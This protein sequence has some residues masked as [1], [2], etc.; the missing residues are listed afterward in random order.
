MPSPN[1]TFAESRPQ[2]FTQDFQCPISSVS[3]EAIE[4]WLTGRELEGRTRFNYVRLIKTL[5]NFAQ[6]RRYFPR[7]VD[8]LEGIEREFTDLSEIEV[9]SPAEM[10]H[11]LQHAR[12]ELIPFLGIDAG[13]AF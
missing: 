1:D 8:P 13:R 10:I 2:R 9:F 7:E 3:P 12:P 4:A 6:T 11:L 5:F